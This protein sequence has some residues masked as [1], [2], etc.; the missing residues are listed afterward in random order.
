[1]AKRARQL[2]ERHRRAGERAEAH[3]QQWLDMTKSWRLASY[4]RFNILYW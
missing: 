1:M 4:R 2:A 3:T